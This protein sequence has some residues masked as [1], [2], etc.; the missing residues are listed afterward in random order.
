MSVF[1][2]L[3]FDAGVARANSEGRL[4]LVYLMKAG[5]H[6]CATMDRFVWSDPRVLE[7][8]PKEV[9]AIQVD[10]DADAATAKRLNAKWEP[11]IAAFKGGVEIDRLLGF[12]QVER[13]FA[14]LDGLA[15]GET[16]VQQY[17]RHLE[18]NP[19][20]VHVH[21]ELGKALAYGDNYAEAIPEY[22][23][24]WKHMLEHS[25][26]MAGI[27]E[28][29][30][31]DSLK[32]LFAM[33]AP[34][35]EPFIAIRG[36]SS[37]NLDAPDATAFTDWCAL[38]EAL[39][40]SAETIA[41]FDAHGERAMKIAALAPVITKRLEP[42]LMK[43]ERWSDLGRLYEK[44]VDAFRADVDLHTKTQA[45]TAEMKAMP[46]IPRD[47]IF[48]TVVASAE[49][50]RGNAYKL[51]RAL[52][53]AGRDSEAQQIADAAVAIDGS[54]EMAAALEGRYTAPTP[55]ELEARARAAT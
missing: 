28:T 20:D 4:L 47:V 31:A 48:I 53:A 32:K 8:L 5:A 7:R 21:W 43:A 1:V 50:L 10:V 27:K 40:D 9:I 42:L 54:A 30:F 41:W 22:V 12:H 34:A 38:N 2:D 44:P 36:A 52:R 18:A 24:V 15:R 37:P 33:H 17:R 51:H 39:D 14:W 11:S 49:K 35:R 3:D 25:P 55:E 29:V 19:N 6:A 46:N 23:W 13:L 26:K 45:S 16:Q